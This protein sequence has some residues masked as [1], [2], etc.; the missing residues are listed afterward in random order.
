MNEQFIERDR[1]SL[2]PFIIYISFKLFK[3][4]IN[5][6][7][8]LE[9]HLILIFQRMDTNSNV[10]ARFVISRGSVAVS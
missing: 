7:N 3:I 2:I 6:I 8:L 5:E 9:I 1:N 4:E 10:I